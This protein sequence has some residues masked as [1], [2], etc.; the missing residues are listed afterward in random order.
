MRPHFDAELDLVD[1][2][3]WVVAIDA[4]LQDA[5]DEVEAYVAGLLTQGAGGPCPLSQQ[6]ARSP[7]PG[8]P[9]PFSIE[10]E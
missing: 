5:A 1:R 4:R 9:H 10:N 2:Q 6:P 3:P 8:D 7:C